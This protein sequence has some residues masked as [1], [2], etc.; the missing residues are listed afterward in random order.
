MQAIAVIVFASSVYSQNEQCDEIFVQSWKRGT[1][2][3]EKEKFEV[4]LY[5]KNPEFKRTII[6]KSG[7][8]YVL[9]IRHMPVKEVALSETGKSTEAWKVELH[10]RSIGEKGNEMLGDNL[11]Q[12][13]RVGTGGD[14]F[15]REN[16]IGYLYPK[17][18]SK[19]VAN[20][21]PLIDGK[22]YYPIRMR[23]KI[24]VESFYVTIQVSDFKLNEID[25]HRVD[26]IDIAVELQNK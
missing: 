16:L 20:G 11:L 12:F 4:R 25:K 7:I 21:K 8:A 1:D 6:S 26:F 9:L 22:F 17:E 2:Q 18:A 15:P 10:H 5:W 13:E 3:I 14:N 24:Q 19:I 23:R